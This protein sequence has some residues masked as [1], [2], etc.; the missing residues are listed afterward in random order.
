M[1]REVMDNFNKRVRLSLISSGNLLKNIYL[2]IY[3]Y[4]K[5]HEF[6]FAV[7]SLFFSYDYFKKV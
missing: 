1:L 3:F 5:F 7:S 4:N 6:F 2:Q